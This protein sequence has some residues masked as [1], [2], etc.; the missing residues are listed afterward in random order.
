HVFLKDLVRVHTAVDIASYGGK[1]INLYSIWDGTVT[2]VCNG[3]GDFDRSRCGDCGNSIN[4]THNTVKVRYCHLTTNSIRV[5]SG[6]R[7]VR[8]Q[9]LGLMGTSGL[10]TDVHLHII[11]TEINGG[12]RRDIRSRLGL[13]GWKSC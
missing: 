9:N 6:Q 1:R 10:S 5:S 12:Q 7:I 11:V 13:N 2:G 4:I 3:A 8:A